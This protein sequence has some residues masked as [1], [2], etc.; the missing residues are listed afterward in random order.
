MRLLPCFTNTIE[1]VHHKRDTQLRTTIPAH[2]QLCMVSN[3]E[4]LYATDVVLCDRHTRR[5]TCS[6]RVCVEIDGCVR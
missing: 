4:R 6:K 2:S 5:C 3:Q 1:H